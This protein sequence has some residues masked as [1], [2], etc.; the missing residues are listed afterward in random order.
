MSKQVEHGSSLIK[1]ALGIAVLIVVIGIGFIAL[2]TGEYVTGEVSQAQGR[3]MDAKYTTFESGIK[4]G[5]VVVRAIENSKHNEDMIT[6]TVITLKN[7]TTIYGYGTSTYKGYTPPST[8]DVSY[9]N[10]GGSFESSVQR[11]NDAVT[12]ITFTQK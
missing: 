6:V 8:G 3:V 1:G 5:D 7:N 2:D 12:G 9:I 11:S 4:S 10:P